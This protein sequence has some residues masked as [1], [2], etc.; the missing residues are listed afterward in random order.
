MI[1]SVIPPLP[2]SSSIVDPRVGDRG[3]ALLALAD[4]TVFPGIAF[5]APVAAGG[6]SAANDP[7]PPSTTSDRAAATG[8]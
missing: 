8:R 4:G 5:G 3:P 6:W 2:L 1:P 7:P